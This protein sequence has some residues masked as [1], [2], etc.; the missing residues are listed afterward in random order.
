[1]TRKSLKNSIGSSSRGVVYIHW[2][3]EPTFYGIKEDW[4]ENWKTGRETLLKKNPESRD[5]D[6]VLRPGWWGAV[7]STRS[8]GGGFEGTQRG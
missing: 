3:C 5:R 4:K 2:D 8:S 7:S 6:D 1:M